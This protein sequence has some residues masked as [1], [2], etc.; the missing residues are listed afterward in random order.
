MLQVNTKYN[1][2][3]RYIIVSVCGVIPNSDQFDFTPTQSPVETNFSEDVTV[4]CKPGHRIKG[5]TNNNITSAVLECVESGTWNST[6]V[7]C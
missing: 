3:S 6:T 2:I 5:S 7:A 1:G 4:K